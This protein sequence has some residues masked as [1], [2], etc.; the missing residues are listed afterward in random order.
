LNHGDGFSIERLRLIPFFVKISLFE[1]LYEICGKISNEVSRIRL[2]ESFET[3]V[4][5]EAD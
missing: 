1:M 2:A 5:G 4:N 3:L